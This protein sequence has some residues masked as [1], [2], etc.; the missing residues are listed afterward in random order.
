MFELS[1]V[2]KPAQEHALAVIM[3]SADEP[4]DLDD[5][6]EDLDDESEDAQKKAPGASASS[7]AGDSHPSIIKD[8]APVSDVAVLEDFSMPENKT[9]ATDEADLK[10]RLDTLEVELEKARKFG[11]LSDEEK[12]HF[13][14]LD[15]E[16]K[17]AFLAKTADVRK[18]D[19][20]KSKSANPVVY[21]SDDGTAFYKSDDARLITL[22]K[23]RD[24]DRRELAKERQD[25]ENATF[26]KRAE[27]ELEFFPGDVAVRA[28][29]LKAVEGIGD[30]EIRTKA[31][32]S[33]K[34]KNDEMS[35]SFQRAGT[36]SVNRDL[37][38]TD[39]D[40]E[41]DSLAKAY[42]KEHNIGYLDA[43]EKVCEQNP[44]L[45]RKA[46]TKQA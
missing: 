17:A 4:E 13:K 35:K 3:K 31:L 33:L 37:E 23:D 34:A 2:D 1:A 12:E 24:A 9:T 38:V 29:I 43:Y 41:L 22:A 36:T 46:V 18:A 5:E 27:T 45:L 25:R 20:E 7:E 30:K 19:I 32:E 16:E 39:A 40:A 11:D 14:S 21:T 15:D 10:K 44:D 28:A 8:A 42:S 26:Q 6:S